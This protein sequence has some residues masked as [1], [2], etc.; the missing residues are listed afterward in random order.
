MIYQGNVFFFQLLT[1]A[2]RFSAQDT[3]A[4]NRDAVYVTPVIKATLVEDH[5]VVGVPFVFLV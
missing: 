1:L 2:V 4:V 5:A 3:P